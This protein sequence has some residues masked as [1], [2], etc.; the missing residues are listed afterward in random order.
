MNMKKKYVVYCVVM[1]YDEDGI[2]DYIKAESG[3]YEDYEN[4]LIR[5]YEISDM[6][7]NVKIE[8]E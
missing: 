4:A 6:G 3:T 8:E 1:A 7:Y 2:M 5:A